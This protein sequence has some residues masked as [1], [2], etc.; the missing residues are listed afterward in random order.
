M[1]GKIV[2][3]E[4]AVREEIRWRLMRALDAGRPYAVTEDIL[5]RTLDDIQM[6]VTSHEIRRQLDYLR[7]HRLVDLSGED[8]QT[9][10]AELTAKGVNVVEYTEPAPAGIAR[11]KQH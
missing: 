3:L 6:P 5:L 7:D 10:N 4:K 8:T 1:N 2:D 11:P 9:W